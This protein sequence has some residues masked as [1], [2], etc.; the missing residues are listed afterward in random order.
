MYPT[1]NTTQKTKKLSNAVGSVLLIFLAFCVVF[2]VGYMLLIFLVFCVVYF[3]GVHVAHLS[4]FL[5]CGI[6]WGVIKIKYL[7]K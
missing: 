5:C 1:N 6:W 3:G 2:V 7:K 4:S